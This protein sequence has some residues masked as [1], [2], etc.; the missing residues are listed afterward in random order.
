MIHADRMTA[1]LWWKPMRPM[2]IALALLAGLAAAEAQPSEQPQQNECARAAYK[3]YN[4]ENLN[5]IMKSL[6]MM[7]VEA[8]IEQRRL[9]ESYCA[10][11]AHCVIGD[12][13]KQMFRLPYLVAFDACLRDEALEKYDAVQRKP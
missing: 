8:T 2:M 3:E 4:R 9:Q 1:A 12:P 11:F 10:K 13:N 6:P 7:S 5:L